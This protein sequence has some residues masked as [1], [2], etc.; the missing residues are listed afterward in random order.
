MYNQFVY[1][2]PINFIKTKIKRIWD[3]KQRNIGDGN[4]TK[5]ERKEGG[6]DVQQ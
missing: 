1:V 2:F 6:G 3:E 4:E 5:R